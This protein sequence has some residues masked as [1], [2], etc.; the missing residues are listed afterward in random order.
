MIITMAT[1]TITIVITSHG[2]HILYVLLA[3]HIREFGQGCSWSEK[4][5]E[6]NYLMDRNH[7][8][9]T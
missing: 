9:H 6:T 8:I 4:V 3:S 2:N 5:Q 7:M 1:E